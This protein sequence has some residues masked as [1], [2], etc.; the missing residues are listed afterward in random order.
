MREGKIS[1]IKTLNYMKTTIFIMFLAGSL[2]AQT[3]LTFD[4][5]CTGQGDF[6]N[7]TIIRTTAAYAVVM[8]PGGLA[9]VALSN[10]PPVLQAEFSYEPDKATAY[11]EAEK[12]RAGESRR[13]RIEQQKKLAALAGPVQKIRVTAILDGFGLCQIQTTNGTFMAYVIGVPGL[14]NSY[15]ASRA[16]LEN[17]IASLRTTPIVATATSKGYG[18]ATR[19]VAHQAAREALADAKEL[20]AETVRYLTEQLADLKKNELQSTTISAYPTG[21]QDNGIPR[22]QAVQ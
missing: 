19:G 7:A 22:W 11:L 10:L 20:N 4:V 12:R 13:A 1:A 8:H 21:L 17:T 3:N 14:V 9:K 18:R 6:T 16:S 5:L 2:C 15:Y